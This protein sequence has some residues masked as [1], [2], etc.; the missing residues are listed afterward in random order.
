MQRVC[1]ITQTEVDFF[2]LLF[3]FFKPNVTKFVETFRENLEIVKQ[4]IYFLR[5]C[6]GNKDAI[7]LSLHVC[8]AINWN[9]CTFM[10]FM[11]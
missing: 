6:S 2:D 9:Y 1:R 5:I 10:V 8:F 4:K 7:T 3:R 11:H